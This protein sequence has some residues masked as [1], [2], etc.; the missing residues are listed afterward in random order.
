MDPFLEDPAV[1][2]DVHDRLIVGLSEALNAQLPAPYYAGIASRVWVQASQRHIGPDVKVLH[3]QQTVNGG[4]SAGGG[5]VAIAEAVIAAPVVVHVPREEVRETFLEL[6]AEPGR[7]RLVTTVE[8]LSL[9]NKSPG[10]HGRDLYV[11]KQQELLNSRVH[12]VEIDLL[13]GG[14]HTT[15]V[16]LHEAV[17]K[18]GAFDYHVC[19]HRFDRLDDYFLYPIRL[20]GRLPRV[21]IPLLPG[22]DPVSVDL[23]AVL[24]RCYDTGQYCRRIRYS[25]DALVPPL[26]GEQDEWVKRLLREKGIVPAVPG[27]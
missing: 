15:A 16:P 19:I 17:A 13:R 4:L 7:T 1:F 22:D 8:V 18:A 10:A 12:L 14:D 20:G 24:D 26:S 5:G 6:Y 21:A 3:P 27:S 25:L 9:S 2:P 23:Q 11:Q